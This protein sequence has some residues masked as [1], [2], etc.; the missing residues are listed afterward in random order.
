MA[1]GLGSFYKGPVPMVRNMVLDKSIMFH[2]ILLPSVH[3]KPKRLATSYSENTGPR[4][5][6][7]A[8][9]PNDLQGFLFPSQVPDIWFIDGTA[10]PYITESQSAPPNFRSYTL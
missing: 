9:S 5:S 8:A 6:T 10:L 1:A 2:L 7:E 3:A 4:W